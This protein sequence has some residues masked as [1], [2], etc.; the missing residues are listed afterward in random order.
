M[1]GIGGIRNYD[2]D[3]PITQEEITTILCAL[4]H[5]GSDATGV[6]ILTN[7]E[8]N[9]LKSDN[10]AWNFTRRQDY[11]DFLNE[12]LVPDTQVVLCHTRFATVGNPREN[13][14][15]HPLVSDKTAIVHNGGI[16]NHDEL[17]KKGKLERLA[18]TDSDII[19]AY[20]D[21]YGITAKAINSMSSDLT[22]SCAAAC[23]NT[24]FP[25]KLLLLRSGS[26]LVVCKVGEK[27]MWASEKEVLHKASRPW[28]DW[29]GFYVQANKSG[30]QVA[31][32]AKD[33]GLIIG[34]DGLEFHTAFRSCYSYNTPDYSRVRNEYYT[35]QAR[36]DKL[37]QEKVNDGKVAA[38]PLKFTEEEDG[39]KVI[40]YLCRNPKCDTRLSVP[41]KFEKTALSELHC[42]NCNWFVE[43][44]VK[45]V[46]L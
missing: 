37:I 36:W 12:Y 3:N 28:Q 33:T 6:A 44:C 10:G 20:V 19:R 27:I 8:M 25:D 15:N 7:G 11:K 14:N 17:F 39:K 42:P 30:L 31:A 1:C 21:K 41:K 43:D 32:V 46:T 45:M 16:H 24:D 40:Y 4:E 34:A 29:R 2:R 18:D 22:G 23:I 9:F 5:R 26:P 38:Q 35:R 13:K